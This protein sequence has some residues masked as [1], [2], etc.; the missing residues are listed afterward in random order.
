MATYSYNPLNLAQ[1]G[2]DKMRFEL[3][4]TVV[5]AEGLSSPLCDEEY[6]AMLGQHKDWRQAKIAC[7]RAIVMKLAYEADTSVDGLSYSLR[8]R[9]DR[10]KAMLEEEEKRA[11]PGV[12]IVHDGALPPHGS[13]PY[14][15]NDLHAN[16]RRF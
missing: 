12:P 5:D 3:G 15:Y 6:A 8:Q 13:T 7:L 14:F 10:W 16:P 11:V 2:V 4:D 9:F 1:E